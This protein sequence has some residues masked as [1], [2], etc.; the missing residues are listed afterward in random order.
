[1]THPFSAKKFITPSPHKEGQL[2]DRLRR[3]QGWAGLAEMLEKLLR[4]AAK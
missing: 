1:M 3:R 4:D 2:I